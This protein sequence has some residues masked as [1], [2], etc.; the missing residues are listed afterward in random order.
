M[1]KLMFVVVLMVLARTASAQDLE[2]MAKWTSYQIVHYKI[3]GE[4][5]GDTVLLK[6]SGKTALD[7]VMARVTDRIE[8]EFDWDQQDYN[9]VGKPVIR[10]FPT[11]VVSINLDFETSDHTGPHRSRCPEPKL[12]GALEFVTGLAVKADDGLRM[13]GI[14]TLEARREQPGGSYGSVF[15][16]SD[17]RNDAR[18][19]A[20]CGEF[21]DTASPVSETSIMNLM[22][23]PAMFLAM[24]PPNQQDMKLTPDRKSIVHQ[25]K[26]GASGYGWTWT[27]TPTGVK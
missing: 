8:V 13:S 27:V 10:N 1:K 17:R 11:K 9:L 3:V 25:D 5:S 6:G 20:T 19:V 4:F 18:P 2:A 22:V 23:V 15:P 7:R 14:L 24:L 21:W 16:P 26:P 12:S